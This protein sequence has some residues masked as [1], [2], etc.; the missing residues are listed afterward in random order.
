MPSGVAI[1]LVVGLGNPGPRYDQT[2]HNA[3]FWFVDELARAHATQL[4][5]ET[6]FS[7]E[8]GRLRLDA[9]DLWLLKP[10]TYMNRSGQSVRAFIDYYKIPVEQVLV[11][12]DDIDLPPGKVKIKRGGGHGG[13]NGLRDLSG[14]LGQGFVRLRLGVG[15]PG[16]RDEVIE[17]VLSR[18]S[19]DEHRAIRDAV[20]EAAG[21]LGQLVSGDLERATQALHSR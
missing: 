12:H 21:V 20:D 15:H 18:P 8:V 1:R 4:K 10:T 7:G 14:H 13:H 6:R 9:G 2:R 16:H 5:R 3:G 11:A 19:A 17:F